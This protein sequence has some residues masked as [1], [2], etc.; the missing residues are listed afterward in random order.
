MYT[1]KENLEYEKKG[2]QEVENVF[3]KEMLGAEVVA[4]QDI[5]YYRK[6]DVD[7]LVFNGDKRYKV[8]VKIDSMGDMTGNLFCEIVSNE[9]K[10][11]QGCFV[12]TEC[13]LWVYY[14]ANTKMLYMFPMDDFRDWVLG[15]EQGVWRNG[16][17]A[18]DVG[19][20]GSYSSKGY[21]VPIHEVL[22]KAP[23]FVKVYDLNKKERIH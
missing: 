22:T 21:L 23:Q 1:M 6:Q 9:S 18:T 2:M 19:N 16:R 17:T 12:Y 4:V 10:G 15:Q 5:T 20:G 8:E 11:T 13:D 7:L 3:F 14:L